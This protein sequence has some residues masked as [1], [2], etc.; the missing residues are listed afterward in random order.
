M[1][2]GPWQWYLNESIEQK[3]SAYF[4][5]KNRLG[6]ES[7][8]YI[9]QFDFR[10]LQSCPNGYEA[11]GLGFDSLLDRHYVIDFIELF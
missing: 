6:K 5:W 9:E 7:V 10:G 3:W 4:L 1:D 2:R 8:L 11:E